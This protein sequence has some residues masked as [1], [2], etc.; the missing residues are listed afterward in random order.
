MTRELQVARNHIIDHDAD[1][2]KILRGVWA[3][4]ARLVDVQ[5]IMNALRW[6]SERKGCPTRH[7]CLR[8][9]LR[10]RPEFKRLVG[11]LPKP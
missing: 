4:D 11:G 8:C 5:V 2:F 3:R 10:E 9:I 1:D 7:L 6:L